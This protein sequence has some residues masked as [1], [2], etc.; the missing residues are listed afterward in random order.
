MEGLETPVLHWLK[1]WLLQ[2][3]NIQTKK[4]KN[5]NHVGQTEQSSY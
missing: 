1:L 5:K 3:T 2:K 4:K